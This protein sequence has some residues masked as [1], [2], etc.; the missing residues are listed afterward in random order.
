MWSQSGSG[1]PTGWGQLR[2]PHSTCLLRVGCSALGLRPPVR[3]RLRAATAEPAGPGTRPPA[4]CPLPCAAPGAGVRLISA[5]LGN[6]HRSSVSKRTRPLLNPNLS[7]PGFPGTGRAQLENLNLD[8]HHGATTDLPGWK[9]PPAG[10]ATCLEP[11][12]S[13]GVSQHL[14]TNCKGRCK[15]TMSKEKATWPRT[16]TLRE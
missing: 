13:P 14:Q 6:P 5:A 3:G 2:S 8:A 11:G 10:S 12:Y 4:Q 1:R 9:K 15:T 16:R 7:R